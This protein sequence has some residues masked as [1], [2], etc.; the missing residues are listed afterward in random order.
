MGRPTIFHA[1]L[2]DRES[3]GTRLGGEGEGSELSDV[4]HHSLS[5][6]WGVV[7]HTQ[8]NRVNLHQLGY[9]SMTQS[10]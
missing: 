8:P 1:G 7:S 10:S 3:L 4:V 9:L 2:S 6:M 5:E